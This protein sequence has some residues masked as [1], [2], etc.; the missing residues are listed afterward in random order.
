MEPDEF[1]GQGGTYEVIDGV[2]HLVPGSRTEDAPH[3]SA[4]P[5]PAPEVNDDAPA[6]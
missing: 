2:R 3:A 5:D 4:N 1:H 6:E